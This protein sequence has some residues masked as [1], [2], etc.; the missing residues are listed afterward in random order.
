MLTIVLAGIA[1]PLLRLEMCAA[2]AFAFGL[3]LAAAYAPIAQA[4]FAT[5]P[6][7]AYTGAKRRW[8]LLGGKGILV[9]AR[10]QYASIRRKGP[11]DAEGGWTHGSDEHFGR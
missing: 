10:L 7:W 4:A 8:A 9:G 5:R 1:T 3:L 11:K 6:K 2:R